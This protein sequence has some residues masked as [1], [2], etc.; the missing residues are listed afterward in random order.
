MC[1]FPTLTQRRLQ[2]ISILLTGADRLDVRGV[3]QSPEVIAVITAVQT[4]AQTD[5]GNTHHCGN[6]N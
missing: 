2:H 6:A 5:P 4:E 1:F 3:D